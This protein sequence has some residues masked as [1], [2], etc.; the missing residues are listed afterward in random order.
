[1]T[2]QTVDKVDAPHSEAPA[3]IATKPT[4]TATELLTAM[5]ALPAG[6]PTRARL[7]DRT[8]EAWLP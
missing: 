8:I 6:H 5:A 1:M 3:A 7:R 4:D 2:V